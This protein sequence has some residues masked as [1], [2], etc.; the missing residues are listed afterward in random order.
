[1]GSQDEINVCSGKKI[2]RLLYCMDLQDK[3][4]DPAIEM[5]RPTS[6]LDGVN[7]LDCPSGHFEGKVRP[8]PYGSPLVSTPHDD[9]TISI[10]CL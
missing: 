10:W 6:L 3:G 2:L 1:M 9:A 4:R 8:T 7:A 5:P